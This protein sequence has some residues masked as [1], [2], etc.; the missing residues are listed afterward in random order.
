MVGFGFLLG[1]LF[2]WV[3]KLVIDGILGEKYMFY[4]VD[5]FCED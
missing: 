2:F 5:F 3:K 1:I 4:E